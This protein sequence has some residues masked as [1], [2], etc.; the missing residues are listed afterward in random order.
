MVKMP[1]NKDVRCPDDESACRFLGNNAAAHTQTW[2]CDF[3]HCVTL[4]G[5]GHILTGIRVWD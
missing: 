3:G 4:D 5:D 1:P 2:E